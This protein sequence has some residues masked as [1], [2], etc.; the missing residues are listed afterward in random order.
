LRLTTN[1]KM[2]RKDFLKRA[3][4]L[5][6]LAFI[7]AAIIESCGKQSYAGPTNVNFTID[8]TNAQNAALNTIG[9]AVTANG[10][11]VVR[12]NGATFN[13]FSATCT[14]QGCTI[15]YNPGNGTLVC[16]C[17][18]GVYSGTTGAVISGPPPS[19]LMTYNTSLNGNILTVTS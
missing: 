7:P 4:A 11:I 14:H 2:E 8:L 17:H 19:A 12:L 16:P 6:G 15:G 18:G 5:C 9:G 1:L 3:C 10:V 13:A